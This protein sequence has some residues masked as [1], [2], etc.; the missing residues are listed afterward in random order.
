MYLVKFKKSKSKRMNNFILYLSSLLFIINSYSQQKNPDPKNWSSQLEYKSVPSIADQ[1]KDGT[2]ILT[3]KIKKKKK[4]RN[5]MKESNVNIVIG[6]SQE[7]ILS[8]NL[9][10]KQQNS[11]PKSTLEPI[12]VF[13]PFVST[14]YLPTDPTGA[15][16]PNHYVAAWNSSFRIFNKEGDP[17]TSS[18]S[19]QSLFG[20]EELGDPIVLYDAQV[21]RFIVTSMANTAV[22]FAISQGPDPFL[23]GW[24]VYTAAS[25]IFSTGDTEND[26]PDYPKYS[27]W[28]DAYYF[29]ANYS[30]VPLFALERDKIINGDQSATIQGINVP[31]IFYSSFRGTQ[32]LNITG[33]NHPTSGNATLVYHQDGALSGVNADQIKLWTINVDWENPANTTISDPLV[34][35]TTP[36]NA[37]FDGGVLEEN[38]TQING[39]EMS[40]GT[41]IISNQAQFRKFETHNSAIF[42]FSVNALSQNPSSDEEQAAVRWYELR[43]DSDGEPWSIYQEGT[44]TAPDGKHAIMGS[45]AMDFQGNIGMGYTSFS[46][47]HFI[48]SNYTGRYAS[49]ELGVM[50]LEE[51]VI[52]TSNT[53]NNYSRYADYVHLTVDPSDDKTFWFNTEIFRNGNRRDVVGVFKVASDFNNDIGIT[54]VDS[55]EDGSLTNSESITVSIFNYGMQDVSGFDLSYQIDSG[56]II[57]ENF[58]G[59]LE[60]SS[61]EQFTFTQTSDLSIVGNSYEILAYTSL[62]GDEYEENNSSDKT[63]IH[64]NPNDVGISVIVSPNSGTN[65]TANEIVT[66]EVSNYGGAD[67]GNLVVSYVVDGVIVDETISDIISATSTIEYSFTS[68]LDLSEFGSYEITAYTSLD[69]DSDASNDSTTKEISNINCAPSAD[70][71]YGDGF[72][73]FELA[74]ISNE[75]GCEGYG[76]FTNLSTDLE[77][78]TSYDLT[79]TTGYSDEFVSV[80]IDYN[81]D[82][83]FSSDELIVDNYEIADGNAGGGSYTETISVQIP[84]GVTLGEHILRAKSNW[85]SVVP[86][87]ACEETQ[88]GE[89]E[90]YMVNIVSGLGIDDLI[91]SSDF[92]II[93]RSEDQFEI[94]LSIDY[95]SSLNFS[96]YSVTGQLLVTKKVFK[97]NDKYKYDLDMSYASSGVYLVK[98]GN[99]SIGYK[100]GKIIVK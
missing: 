40:A 37:Y 30:D 74:D 32:M 4:E 95:S 17:V 73:L 9:V 89:T 24:H 72:Q 75:S 23:N 28:S 1:I 33:D 42:N 22:N 82:F 25:N 14:N 90:D 93:T 10:K 47:N 98:L 65:L 3:E 97:S 2:I 64:L 66:V 19:L 48:E 18:I 57:T 83:A 79:V 39:V 80:W 50:S 5:D 69:S 77:A 45:M 20:A 87:D 91:S 71:S 62:E 63:V 55:P 38:L 44:Y 99:N 67:Q 31:N 11:I 78:G 100:I 84:E 34:L 59:T 36:F 61:T 68:T 85:N 58:S 60:S 54:S 70:C 12:L 76:D 8:K 35:Y 15:V 26:F 49:D 96:V 88:Y 27:I 7:S 92:S 56:E 43:Q 51:G 29:T 21:D 81:N 16:G 52:L 46:E 6:K 86:A 41:M 94:N 53:Q 13:E